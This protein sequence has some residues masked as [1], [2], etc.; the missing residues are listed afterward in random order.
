MPKIIESIEMIEK[1]E[2]G[3]AKKSVQ[4]KVVRY[5]DEPEYIKVYLDTILY[6]KDLEKSYNPILLSILKRMTYASYR[7]KDGGQIIVV[8]SYIKK[9]IAEDAGVSVSRVNQAFTDFTKGEILIRVGRGTYQVNPHLFGKG[10]WADIKEI[11]MNVTFDSNGKTIASQ[12]DH[13][14]QV[15]KAKDESNSTVEH[16]LTGTEAWK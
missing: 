9:G 5:E 2:N 7:N 15:K 6:L 10:D 14:D 16:L 8:N 13:H 3:K 11:R 12:I 1:D 4:R